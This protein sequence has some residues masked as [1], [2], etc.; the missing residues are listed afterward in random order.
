MEIIKTR[1][2]QTK[3]GVIVVG[4]EDKQYDIEW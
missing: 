4:R 1:Q 3:Q 2:N